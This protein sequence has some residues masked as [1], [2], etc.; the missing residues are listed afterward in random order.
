MALPARQG[1]GGGREEGRERVGRTKWFKLHVEFNL[2]Y[3]VPVRCYVPVR[4]Q[5]QNV[6]DQAHFFFFVMGDVLVLKKKI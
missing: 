2:R 5:C 3:Y 6:M 4:V 1:R